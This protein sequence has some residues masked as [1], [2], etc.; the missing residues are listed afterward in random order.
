MTG[1]LRQVDQIGPCATAEPLADLRHRSDAVKGKGMGRAS[2]IPF[3]RLIW[4][5]ERRGPRQ[6]LTRGVAFI[7]RR[8]ALVF[9]GIC[10]L[11]VKSYAGRELWSLALMGGR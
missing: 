9:P 1:L 3:Y 7:M 8:T 10:L 11:G 6:D 2:D 5:R 4:G